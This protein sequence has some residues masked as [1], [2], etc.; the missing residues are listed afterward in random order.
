MAVGW[1]GSND[2]V[3]KRLTKT[4]DGEG[5]FMFQEDEVKKIEAGKMRGKP[6][7]SSKIAD[8]IAYLSEL[9]YDLAIAPCD[10]VSANPGF[11][12]VLDVW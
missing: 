12:S 4:G 1:D 7:L 8:M 5:I 11:E 10:N 6:D 3:M 9:A 2:D